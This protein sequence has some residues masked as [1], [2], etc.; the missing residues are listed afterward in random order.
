MRGNVLRKQKG[1]PT[2]EQA[3]HD[4]GIAKKLE[5][6]TIAEYSKRL[7]YLSFWLPKPLTDIRKLTVVKMHNELTR[8]KGEATANSA[9][10][11]LRA[12]F[13]F[14]IAFYD[15]PNGEPLIT[16][17]PVAIL[18]AIKAWNHVPPRKRHIVYELR[19][20]LR[21][22]LTS[23]STTRDYFLTLLLTG[24]RKN[25]A[26][27]LRWDDV[28]LKQGTAL[29]RYTKNGEDHQIVFSDFLQRMFESR[30]ESRGRSPYVFPGA[31][32]GK[33]MNAASKIYERLSEVSGVVFTPHDLRR[34]FASVADA[35][36]IPHY[37]LKRL[38]NHRSGS[39]VTLG[40]CCSVA[41]AVSRTDATNYGRHI[42]ASGN[43]QGGS[44]VGLLF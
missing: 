14:A 4:Y 39:D 19:P 9:F 44:Y 41:R 12:I 27:L 20:W 30:Y 11:V 2:L 31:K 42:Q 21:T 8:E 6:R 16:H 10:R 25:E 38:L 29:I 36:N 23:E 18:S 33:P 34:T 43:K 28:Y 22:V 1:I 17:S 40:L 35:L 24:L 26:A 5:Q 7:K 15:D 3:F 32:P 37:S 13:N